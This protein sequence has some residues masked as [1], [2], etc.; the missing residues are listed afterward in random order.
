MKDVDGDV[1][2]LYFIPSAPSNPPTHFR[3]PQST[4]QSHPPHLPHPPIPVIPNQLTDQSMFPTNQVISSLG[5][6]NSRVH[7]VSMA[8]AV[9]GDPEE[10][11]KFRRQI[12]SI[13]QVRCGRCGRCVRVCVCVC[14]VMQA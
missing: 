10:E 6:F 7:L 5:L 4:D 1:D 12:P 11:P 14:A 13:A 9:K 8:E 3:H 2:T